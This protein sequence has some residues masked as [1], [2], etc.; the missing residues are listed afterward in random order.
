M[1]VLVVVEDDPGM[2]V[3]ITELLREDERL[4]L[5]GEITNLEDAIEAARTTQ[6]DLMILDHFIEGE[7]MGLQAAPMLKEAAPEACIVLFTSHDLSVE[8]DRE[9]SIDAFLLKRDMNQ[10]L[11]TVRRVLGLS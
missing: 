11:P 9:P 8:A 7:V 6:P 5:S 4:H 2:R 3:L 10:L 1:N